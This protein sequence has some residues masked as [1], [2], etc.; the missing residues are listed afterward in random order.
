MIEPC[1]EKA[2]N[3]THAKFSLKQKKQEWLNL[4]MNN[5]YRRTLGMHEVE[6]AE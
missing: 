6:D 3:C 1:S 2:I 5:M 4:K